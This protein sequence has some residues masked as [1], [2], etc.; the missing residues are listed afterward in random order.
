[1]TKY[2]RKFKTL[3]EYE[4]SVLNRPS[5]SYVEDGKRIFIENFYGRLSDNGDFIKFNDDRFNPHDYV[6]KC[7][8]FD[9]Q[10]IDWLMEMNYD[11]LNSFIK[12]NTINESV[13][14]IGIYDLSTN[15]RVGKID[16][17]K[18]VNKD[19]NKLYSFGV[20]S[21]VHNQNDQ[22]AECDE[23]IKHALQYFNSTEHVDFT[24]ICGDLTLD[25]TTEELSRYNKN[26]N[27][28][29]KEKP[30]YVCAGN[31]D[32]QNSGLDSVL[33]K[34]YTH[35]D[36]NY[37]IEN[38]NDIFI[39]FSLSKYSL[40]RE[41]TP[42]SINGINW[43]KEQLNQYKN[44]RVFI[45]THLFFPD[46]SGSFKERY[47]HE[48]SLRGSEF[49]KLKQ[50]RRHFSNTIWFSGH[51]HWKW[52][53]QKYQN[54][55]NIDRDGCWSVHIPSCAYPIDS[56][57]EDGGLTW[58][59]EVK[60]L[61]SEGAVVD[62]YEDYINIRAFDLKNNLCLPNCCYRLD[63]NIKEDIK[64]FNNF[65]ESSYPEIESVRYI[66][67]NDIVINESKEGSDLIEVSDIGDNYLLMKF[68][69]LGSGLLAINSDLYKKWES[70]KIK[71]FVEDVKISY[72][73]IEYNEEIPSKLGFYKDVDDDY[74]LSSC[75]D[76][77]DLRSKGHAQINVSSRYTSKLP[78][79]IKI[80]FK[81]CYK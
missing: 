51:S 20:L 23:D 26:V 74:T 40:G 14:V 1:M 25:G 31:H 3:S 72:D 16:C 42:Y 81:L 60:P 47:A 13:Y 29:L 48:N 34:R 54:N 4:S 39:F 67:A 56:V 6:Y 63:T 50:L 59:R 62:V 52:N 57:S 28:F 58:S 35:C 2:I 12:E 64:E 68:Y 69:S 79:Y 15:K 66:T 53:L 17:S 49:I 45:F 70:T 33:W 7:E 27:T 65:I 44:K 78:V 73:G 43:L 55:A 77:V 76:M 71:L 41:G 8:D 80:K 37:V 32:A 61:E 22:Y 46:L 36:K 9:Y 10:V 30:I 18:K 75:E 38:D 24:C 19:K 21:D 5:I 11:E